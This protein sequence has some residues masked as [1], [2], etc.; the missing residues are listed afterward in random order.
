MPGNPSVEAASKAFYNVWF[1]IGLWAKPTLAGRLEAV[2]SSL[3]SS[4]NT[5]DTVSTLSIQRIR[6]APLYD[7]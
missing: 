6:I 3:H 2:A 1:S 5:Q 4:P 7:V